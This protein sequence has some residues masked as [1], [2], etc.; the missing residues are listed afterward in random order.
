MFA[1]LM[2]PRLH[3]SYGSRGCSP[4]GF[5]LSIAPIRGVGL[6]RLIRS[7]KIIP[8]SPFFQEESTIRSKTSR[9]GR[10]AVTSRECGL[11]R[12]YSS[13]LSTAFMNSSVSATEMLKLLSRFVWLLQVM[14]SRM[15]GWSTRRIPMLA[16]RP[17][18][19]DRFGGRVEHGHEGDRAGGDSLRRA[20]DVGVRAQAGEGEAGP[21]AALVDEG[22]VLDR[23]EDRFHRVLHREHETRRQ[24]L[25]LAARVHQRG[26]VGEEVQ[27][28]HHGVER[29]R[30]PEHHLGEGAVVEAFRQGDVVRHPGRHLLGGF[31][32]VPLHP[33]LEVAALQHR[34]GVLRD[35]H[36]AVFPQEGLGPRLRRMVREG[37]AGGARGAGA[38]AGRRGRR[39]GC[40]DVQIH[41]FAPLPVRWYRVRI[42][43]LV[44]WWRD[45]YKILCLSRTV[46]KKR[47]RNKYFA[48]CT[49]CRAFRGNKTAC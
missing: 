41:R 26:G 10:R 14:K 3:D 44:V 48:N 31:E 38:Q 49:S 13:P 22:G 43:Y 33:L 4:Q 40:G 32:G 28:E 5:V 7:M 19:L 47:G 11:T 39:Q 45:D 18:L 23:L 35:R 15:S 46:K 9:A 42:A 16:P 24:L 37:L 29:L 36:G 8:G 27:P 20:D 34:S 1:R 30:P 12:L 2:E 25:K 6:S 17:A 21:P